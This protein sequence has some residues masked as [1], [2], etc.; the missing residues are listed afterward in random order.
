M[1][2]V[3]FPGSR[4]KG[5]ILPALDRLK[6]K[7]IVRILDLML[8]RKDEAGNV[9]VT[10][11]TDLEWEE[12]TALGSYLGGLAGLASGGGEVG[13]ERGALEG[14][15]E[16]ADGHIFDNDDIFRLTEALGDDTSAA[17]VLIEHTWVRPLLDAVERAGGVELMNEWIRPEA[18][19]T[20]ES[21]PPKH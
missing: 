17:V 4:F 21:T 10:T 15:A 19:L 9:M 12:A 11:A 1:L 5:E 8:V 3:A 16:L 20:L 13:F 14:A 18:I 2:T 7:R 6:R